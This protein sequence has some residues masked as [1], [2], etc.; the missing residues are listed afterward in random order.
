[1]EIPKPI[2]EPNRPSSCLGL[3]S[4]IIIAGALLTGLTLIAGTGFLAVVASMVA[5]VGLQYLL[6]GW[7]LPQMLK[8]DHLKGPKVADSKDSKFGDKL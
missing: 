8:E 6:C 7:W 2:P 1:M 4:A 5:F 3:F